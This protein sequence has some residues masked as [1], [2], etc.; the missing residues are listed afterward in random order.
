MRHVIIASLAAVALA[1]CA[2]D[3]QINPDKEAHEQWILE[4]HVQKQSLNRSFCD[5]RGFN[6][7]T[8]LDRGYSF[9]CKGGGY[10]YLIKD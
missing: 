7:Y 4:R 10:V 9:A 6:Y 2:S 5:G 1:G 3:Y 8:E